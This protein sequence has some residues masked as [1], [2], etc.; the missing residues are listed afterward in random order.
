MQNKKNLYFCTVFSKKTQ[1]NDPWCNWQHV[2]FWSRRVQVRALA[3]QPRKSL[4]KSAGFCFF[5]QLV[6]I[7]FGSPVKSGGF[8]FFKQI[9]SLLFWQGNIDSSSNILFKTVRS[10]LPEAFIFGLI[11]RRIRKIKA[12]FVLH[13]SSLQNLTS[14]G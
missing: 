6:F 14:D 9:F 11:Q 3:G 8:N 12:S 4:Q 2:W 7:E 13:T 1:G 10:F 5:Y